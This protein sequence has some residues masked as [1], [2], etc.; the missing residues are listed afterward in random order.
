MAYG[1]TA[2]T[3]TKF[4]CRQLPEQSSKY[5]SSFEH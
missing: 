4:T 1:S 5:K 3:V 2:N